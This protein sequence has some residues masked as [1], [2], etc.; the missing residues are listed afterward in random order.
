MYD[1]N[2]TTQ[3]TLLLSPAKC[4]SKA[5]NVVWSKSL[6]FFIRHVSISN[7]YQK[8]EFH[9]TGFMNLV[10]GMI[11]FKAI[12]NI[13]FPNSLIVVSHLFIYAI[14]LVN[15]DYLIFPTNFWLRPIISSN[16]NRFIFRSDHLFS[17]QL[18]ME[19]ALT[20]Q[21]QE[22]V[23]NG[24]MVLSVISYKNLTNFL[25]RMYFERNT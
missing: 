23:T 13:L 20:P 15:L 17:D 22:I 25:P 14:F 16:Q 5:N 21:L 4:E 3:L 8:L 6:E 10:H 9:F 1:L 24:S 18:Y 11:G 7:E 2:L 19:M 12:M